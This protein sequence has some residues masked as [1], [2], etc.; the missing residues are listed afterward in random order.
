MEF[1]PDGKLLASGSLDHSVV[2]WELGSRQPVGRIEVPGDQQIRSLAFSEDGKLLAVGTTQSI[3]LWD[4]TNRRT[5]DPVL[6]GFQGSANCLAFSPDSG[7]LASGGF[8]KNVMLWDVAARKPLGVPFVGHTHPVQAVAFSPD[9]Q[10]LASAGLD[11]KVVLW[12]LRLET[13]RSRA[14]ELA[15]RNLTPEEWNHHLGV[16]QRRKTCPDLP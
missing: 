1:S 13:W 11:G 8:N 3:T 7:L 5:L 14:C 2:V 10:T 4:V 6:T 9:G 16:E 15:N 12:D